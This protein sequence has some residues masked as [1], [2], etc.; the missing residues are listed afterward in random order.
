[1]TTKGKAKGA[2]APKAVQVASDDGEQA[3][4][5]ENINEQLASLATEISGLT[6]DPRNARKHSRKNIKAIAESLRDHGQRKPIVV[7]RSG[8]MLIVRAG[9]GTVEAAKS[10]G[11]TRVAA[12][13][14][15]EGDE[16]A[17]KFALRDNRSAEL[18]EWDKETLVALL[19]E[20]ASVEDL[21]GLGWDPE[22]LG[23]VPATVSADDTAGEIGKSEELKEKW[24]TALGQ[25]WK[26]GQ[27]R[28]MCGDSTDAS[29]VAKLMS[30]ET[31]ALMQTDPPYGIAYVSNANSKG[32]ASGHEEIEN[33]ELDGPALQAF[34][35]ATIRAAVP[36]LTDTCAFYL[37]HPML[38]QGTFFAAAAAADIL[39]H[40]QI[41]WEKPSFVFGRGDYHWKH[42]LCF[43][44]W[45]KGHRPPFYGERNQTTIWPVGRETSDLHPTAKPV[46]LW[47]PPIHN[48]TRRGEIMYEPF[49]GSGSQILAAEQTSRRCFAMEL[50]PQYVA[51]A[52]ERWATLTSGKP[53]L[54]K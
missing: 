7:Q 41:I 36:H 50:S 37:W 31:A 27:H 15:E 40:R 44:G 29:H 16:A 9:N 24:D 48:H 46:A 53:E 6:P 35:E 1:M 47:F 8:P 54:L 3:M 39:I 20:V 23:I 13:V 45:R 26:L 2:K 28:I 4:A 34:L 22:E 21:P 14:I 52:L 38:T 19:G 12:V 43:Y 11:W 5:A 51:V 49:S 42:E 10:L 33:D 18:A 17:V 32:Q 30:G 25:V